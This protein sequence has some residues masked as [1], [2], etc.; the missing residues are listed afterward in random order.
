ME[1]VNV[2]FQLMFSA[3]QTKDVVYDDVIL[4]PIKTETNAAYAMTSI[5]TNTNAAY[6]TT[7][8]PTNTNTA[9]AATTGHFTNDNTEYETMS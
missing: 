4:Q 5:P 2:H 3:P 7:S 8:I 1:D 6:A 9:Y